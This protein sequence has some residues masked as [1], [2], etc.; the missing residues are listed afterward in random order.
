MYEKLVGLSSPTQ[1][2]YE[3]RSML[4]KFALFFFGIALWHKG[5]SFYAYYLLSIAWVLDG[6]LHRFR[7]TMNEPL[8]PAIL[9]LCTVFALG[10]LW[11]EYPKLGFKVWRRYIAFLVFIPYL[12]L[13]NKERLPWAIGG[14]L[15]GYFGVMAIGIYQ[16][17]V[18]GVQGIPPLHMPHLFFSSMIGIGVMVTL[19]LADT[20]KT[21]KVRALLWLLAVFLLFIQFNQGA[22]GVLIATLISL[23]FMVSLLHKKEIK[24]LLVTMVA[25]IVVAGIFAYNSTT[26]HER[27]LQ[28]KSDITLFKAENYSTSLG[29]RLAIWDVGLHGIA[30]HPF[31]GHGTGMAASYFDKTRETYKGGLYSDLSR[32]VPITYHYHNDWIEIGMHLGAIGLIAYAF[33][34][35]SWFQTLRAHRLSIFGATL[36]CFIFLSGLSD[37]FVIFRQSLFLLLVITAIA[38][39]WQ[40]VHG[41][42]L[43]QT[44]NRRR[45]V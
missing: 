27:M 2:V 15:I 16:W 39:S 22:R 38:I 5:P 33:L 25:L 14:L 18:V 28:A 6:G 36:V 44:E 31:F 24:R 10:I 3:W 43:R 29:Y 19:Y 13:L 34:L 20:S 41:E 37:N 21:K 35:W 12:S 7:Q 45:C 4:V 26:L 17:L 9:I 1:E 30:E 23:V 32:I 40:K 11:S 8:V 42:A